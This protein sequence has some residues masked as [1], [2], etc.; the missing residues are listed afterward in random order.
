LS[1]LTFDNEGTSR[2]H[3]RRAGHRH[4]PGARL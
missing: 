1:L 4:V 2:A 3:H